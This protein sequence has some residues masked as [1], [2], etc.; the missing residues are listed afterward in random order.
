MIADHG[1]NCLAGRCIRRLAR[2]VEAA[3]SGKWNFRPVAAVRHRR[4]T[5]VRVA[6]PVKKR[7]FMVAFAVAR[8]EQAVDYFLAVRIWPLGRGQV[9]P[10]T[11]SALTCC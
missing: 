1:L 11:F 8:Q 2:L 10:G 9:V 6:A 7:N 4:Q 5:V 3:G